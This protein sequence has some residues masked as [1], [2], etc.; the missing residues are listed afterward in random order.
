[1]PRTPDE[2]NRGLSEMRIARQIDGLSMLEQIHGPGK[3]KVI[4]ER[5]EAEDAKRT[6]A[7][8]GSTF[9]GMPV[10]GGDE[11]GAEPGLTTELQSTQSNP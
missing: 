10:T 7:L 8:I 5:L 9:G 4:T 3:A 1:L 2:I 11:P 6:Q